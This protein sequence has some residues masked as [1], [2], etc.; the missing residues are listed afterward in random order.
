[1]NFDTTS[2]AD[3]KLRGRLFERG[4][5]RERLL[6]A[7]SAERKQKGNTWNADV[8][9]TGKVPAMRSIVHREGYVTHES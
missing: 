3:D 5:L 9:T 4:R 6:R 1:M 8:C 2:H 7:S